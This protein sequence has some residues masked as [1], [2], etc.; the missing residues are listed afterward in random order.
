MLLRILARPERVVW[1]EVAEPVGKHP[2]V[3]GT[4]PLRPVSGREREDGTDAV[5]EVL[6]GLFQW[7][8][9][10]SSGPAR[11]RGCAAC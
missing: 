11:G 2:V 8:S 6:D 9:W 5:K 7:G 4:S 1:E 10:S 3:S